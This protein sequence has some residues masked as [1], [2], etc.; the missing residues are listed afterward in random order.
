MRMSNHLDGSYYALSI[1]GEDAAYFLSLNEG[2]RIDSMLSLRDEM[3]PE[4]RVDTVVFSDLAGLRTRLFI[5]QI[6]SLQ[7]ATP[8]QRQI[9]AEISAEL[10]ARSLE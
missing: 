7:L 10:R 1:R 3:A 9:T 5:E 6:A 4:D 8:E 2:Q